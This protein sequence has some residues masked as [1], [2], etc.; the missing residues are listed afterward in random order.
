MTWQQLATIQTASNWIL[1]ESVTGTLFRITHSVNGTNLQSLRSVIAQA[2]DESANNTYFDFRR[3]AFKPESEAFIFL[4]PAG[5]LNRKL[6]IKRLDNLA[7]NWAITIEVLDGMPESI[8]LPIPQSEVIG[9]EE[10]LQ[11]KA[12]A[13]S[14]NIHVAD[15]NNPH[16]IT[17]EKI[18]AEVA[19]TGAVAATSAIADHINHEDPHIQYATDATV[20]LVQNAVNTKETAGTAAN[21]IASHVAE[22]DPHQQYATDFQINNVLLLLD[23]KEAVGVAANLI[24]T[25]TAAQIPQ[26]LPTATTID[27]EG[28][29]AANGILSVNGLIWLLMDGA[30]IGNP[31]SGATRYA[32]VKAQTLFERLWTNPNLAIFAANGSASI[33][34][35]SA[36]AD[37]GA[38]KRLALPDL[39]G[40]VIIPAGT[41]IGLTAKTRGQLGGAETHTL[42]NNE[43]PAHVH[44]MNAYKSSNEA[45]G[46]GLT[47]TAAFVD[48]V[49][50][51]APVGGQ[52]T[53][54]TGGGGAHNNLQPYYVSAGKLILAGKA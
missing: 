46:Y 27:Y 1:T 9:L 18:G 53:A 3:L 45:L 28:A 8:S 35:A 43:T 36:V 49:M 38:S 20:Q 4:Q 39:R 7:D 14:L 50:I 10:E 5:L 2:F 6:A 17:P 19:G 40:R 41:G 16:G 44:P 51:A 48:N 29:I 23:N 42:S 33:K 54:S 47:Q 32:D 15:P 31:T 52:N 25:L 26:T 24:A 11:G 22:P 30:T 34:G 37:F 12:A 13:E 21:A